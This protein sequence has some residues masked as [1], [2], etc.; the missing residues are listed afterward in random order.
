MNSELFLIAYGGKFMKSG[1]RFKKLFCMPRSII[2]AFLAITIFIAVASLNAENTKIIIISSDDHPP[3]LQGDESPGKNPGIMTDIVKEAFGS[4]GIQVK[5]MAV[6]AARIVWSLLENKVS[7]TVGPTGWFYGKNSGDKVNFIPLF[8]ASFHFYFMK[9]R[10]P[11]GLEYENLED[12][13]GYKIGYMYGGACNYLLEKAGLTV[14]KVNDR[15]QNTKKLF[16][17]RIDLLVTESIGGWTSIRKLYPGEIDEFAMAE[18][19]IM[20]APGCII[21]KKDQQELIQAFQRGFSVIKKNGTYLGIV[22]RYY[23]QQKIPERVLEFIE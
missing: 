7:A 10:F 16:L 18:K 11:E 19:I 4:Q 8:P 15:D 13:K 17:G 2:P 9:K 22:N 5:Y 3:L 1:T 14:E 21:F 6:P 20:D 12:L 23:D